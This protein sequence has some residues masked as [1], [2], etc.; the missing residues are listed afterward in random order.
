VGTVANFRHQ[1]DYPTLLRAAQRVMQ[2]GAAVRF[3]AIGDG[4]LEREL[5]RLHRHLGLGIDSCSWDERRTRP[6][7]LLRV[8]CSCCRRGSRDCR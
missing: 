5:F 2:S 6:A 7:Y 1:K 8:I 3:V 4:P